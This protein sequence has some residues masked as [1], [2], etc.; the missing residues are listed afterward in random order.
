MPSI[1]NTLPLFVA[2]VWLVVVTSPAMGQTSV[3]LTQPN[4]GESFESGT[5]TFIRWDYTG[6]AALNVNVYLYK[7]ETLQYQLGARELGKGHLFWSIDPLLPDGDDYRVRLEVPLEGGS[8]VDDY[9]DGLF[10]ITTPPPPSLQLTSPNGG[11]TLTAGTSALVT[12]TSSGV[13]WVNLY[14]YK[15]GYYLGYIGAVPATDGGFVWELDPSLLTGDDYTLE[16]YACPLQGGDCL[17]DF[18]DSAFHVSGVDPSLTLVAPNGGEELA[19]GGTFAITW[20]SSAA[21]WV[22]AYLYKGGYYWT[23][24]G[25]APA[26]DGGFAWTL[27]TGLPAGSDYTIWL[28]SSAMSGS[29]L[30]DESDAPFTITSGTA[31]ALALTYP[32][33]GETFTAGT[34]VVITWTSSN[35]DEHTADVHLYK[36]GQWYQY[37]GSVAAAANGYL[38]NIS[39]AVGDGSDYTIGVTACRH[40]GIEC[41]SDFSDGPFSIV[42]SLPAP[43]LRL[44]S[45]NGGEVWSAGTTQ[46]ITWIAENIAGTV[47]VYLGHHGGSEWRWIGAAPAAAERFDWSICRQFA[48]AADYMIQVAWWGVE[49]ELFDT[50]D[51]PF[52]VT[53]TQ[54]P[55]ALI[56]PNGGEL[57]AAGSDIVVAWTPFDGMAT[58][59]LYAGTQVVQTVRHVPGNAGSYQWR[60]CERVGD[61]SNYTLRLSG[62]SCEEFFED[63]SDGAFTVEGS[64]PAPTLAILSPNG[65]EAWTAGSRRVVRWRAGAG[66]GDVSISCVRQDTGQTTYVTSAPVSAGEID[67]DICPVL[68]DGTYRMRVE[69][70]DCIRIIDDSDADFTITGSISPLPLEVTGP[71]GGETYAAGSIQT[72]SWTG[73]NPGDTAQAVLWKGG[74]WKGLIGT[75]PVEQGGMSWPVCGLLESADYTI[76]VTASGCGGMMEDTSA[77]FAISGPSAGAGIEVLSPNG[78]ET[79]QAGTSHTIAWTAQGLEGTV[80]IYCWTGQVYQPVGEAP[81]AA[82][83][84]TWNLCPNLPEGAVYRVMIYGQTCAGGIQDSSDGLF[85]VTGGTTLDDPELVVTYPL[86]GEVW[87]AGSTRTVTWSAAKPYG[88]V[89]VKLLRSGEH[90]SAT[91]EAAAPMAAGAATLTLPADLPPGHDYTVL[92]EMS[93]CFEQTWRQSGLLFVAPG[94]H[95]PADLDDDG[96]VDAADAAAFQACGTGPRIGLTDAN[97][98]AAD[99]DGDGDADQDDFGRFQRCYSG[100][101]RPARPDCLD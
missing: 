87:K 88:D 69:W 55:P 19:A 71:A 63:R 101:N 12:W 2:S 10:S 21:Q 61:G 26:V 86:G 94:A 23:Y 68:G 18:S 45:P 20:A 16:A 6:D 11:E 75:A 74:E 39:P 17:S 44:T 60:I 92:L 15:G 73:G 82:G 46:A 7:G 70:N 8:F 79:L 59:E 100:P 33:G 83:T 58:L 62:V 13:G 30:M 35:V 29:T 47:D 42:G 57:F 64:L 85:T 77:T 80:W 93:H 90:G 48:D 67:W 98:L 40:G 24:I 27:G 89:V 28:I 84:F 53:D 96:D 37:L 72:I 38:W 95:Q 3:T 54:P 22:D 56:A 14:L 34:P 91:V 50:S 52:T 9:S 4:G 43:V 36:A 66:G 97:C 5:Y 51:G 65:G 1:T 78:G 41:T 81:A 99:L 32:Q 76:R 31:P 25:G 49:D